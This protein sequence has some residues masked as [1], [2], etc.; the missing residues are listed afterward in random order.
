M[1]LTPRRFAVQV[2]HG[3]EILLYQQGLFLAWDAETLLEA[4]S[5]SF[6]PICAVTCLPRSL[7]RAEQ[8]GSL[9]H[10]LSREVSGCSPALTWK[11]PRLEDR[12][13][14]LAN[15]TGLWGLHQR[16]W[17][18]GVK[19]VGGT[20]PRHYGFERRTGSVVN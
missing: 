6:M 1:G 19:T 11:S 17:Q 14:S 8:I 18:A 3:P 20:L 9:P 7:S 4:K 5:V 15:F 2:F 16:M 13:Q 12:P 10:A